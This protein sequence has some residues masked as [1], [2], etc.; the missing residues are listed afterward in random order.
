ML[1]WIVVW[2]LCIGIVL[3]FFMGTDHSYEDD[4]R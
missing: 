1:V 2:A 4:E 3:A